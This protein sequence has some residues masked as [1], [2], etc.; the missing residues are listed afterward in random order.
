MFVGQKKMN[1]R[2]DQHC[3]KKSH[4]NIVAVEFLIIG[5]TIKCQPRM[6]WHN[7]HIGISKIKSI[8]A[9]TFFL[10]FCIPNETENI[11]I[12]WREYKSKE[13]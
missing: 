3:I 13:R 9:D 6:R 12:K 11:G 1:E 2:T 7:D 10:I 8:K 4:E 5:I